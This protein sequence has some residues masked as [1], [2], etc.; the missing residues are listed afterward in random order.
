MTNR[1]LMIA[2]PLSEAD[3]AELLA[4]MRRIERRDPSQSF[5]AVV[6]ELAGHLSLEQMCEMLARV[7]PRVAGGALH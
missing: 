4:V 7:F 1:A 6:N 5:T 2:G 3:I